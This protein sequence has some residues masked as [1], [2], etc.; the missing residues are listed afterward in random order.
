MKVGYFAIFSMLFTLTFCASKVYDTEEYQNIQKRI[1]Q[2][3]NGTK[4]I[5]SVVLLL[6][7]LYICYYLAK[8]MIKK[9]SNRNKT[10]LNESMSSNY[11]LYNEIF[12]N[13]ND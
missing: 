13:K 9:K 7:S 3:L 11:S 10:I 5:R 2:G 8:M 4:N 6:C 1:L 12:N